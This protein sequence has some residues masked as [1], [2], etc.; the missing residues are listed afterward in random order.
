MSVGYILCFFYFLPKI[1]KMCKISEKKHCLQLSCN[2]NNG[3]TSMND[4]T[5]VEN[6][7]YFH[8]M[9]KKYININISKRFRPSTLLIKIEKNLF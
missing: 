6:I 2:Q 9:S 1:F 8:Y 5:Q 4:P 3:Y 7:E